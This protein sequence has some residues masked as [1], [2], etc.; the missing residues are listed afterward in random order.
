MAHDKAKRDKCRAQYVQG[1]ALPSAA[2]AAGIAH[3]TARNWKRLASAAGDNWDTARAARRMGAGHVESLTAQILEE[4]SEQFLTTIDQLKSQKDLSAIQ[5]AEVLN[6][7]ADSYTKTLSAAGRAN[8]KL[9][10]LAVG[11]DVLKDL[12]AFVAQE[13]PKQRAWFIDLLEAYGPV[14]ASRLS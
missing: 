2:Q 10:R 7:L 4:L 3:A 1:Q 12:S 8:P 5:R 14:M 9:S 6:R 13:Q 11:M